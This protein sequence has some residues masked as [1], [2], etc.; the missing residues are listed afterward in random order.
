MKIVACRS[1]PGLGALSLAVLPAL[2]GTPAAYS[3]HDWT[4][5][6]MRAIA[7]VRSLLQ[8]LGASAW[9]R[10]D[11]DAAAGDGATDAEANLA[12][13]TLEDELS[14]AVKEQLRM[15]GALREK[16][17]ARCGRGRP[18]AHCRTGCIPAGSGAPNGRYP[19]QGRLHLWR[20]NLACAAGL[21]ASASGPLCFLVANGRG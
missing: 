10:F 18:P 17:V 20:K 1:A 9:L 19:L 16:H 7:R 5:M 12:L 21:A 6:A 2:F 3:A 13:R 11:E 8:E 4:I 14:A 15:A